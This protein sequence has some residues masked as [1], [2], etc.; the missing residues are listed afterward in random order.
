MIDLAIL[1]LLA[2]QELHGYELTKRLPELLGSPS[3]VSFGSVYPALSR[4]ER[5]GLVK[6][7]E[8]AARVSS[9]VP[10]TGSLAGELAAARSRA[11]DVAPAP[12]RARKVYGI[13]A[14][15]EVRLVEQLVD[16]GGATTAAGFDLRLALFHHLEKA[17]RLAVIDERCSALRVRLADVRRA[18]PPDA[19]QLARQVRELASIEYD[20]AWLANLARAEHARTIPGGNS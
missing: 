8:A 20:L 16:P 3:S 6:A 19:Y 12:R 17:Q 7:V 13:T 9:P 10:M 18:Q 11:V 1:G 15:G 2:D 14:K 5:D 4:L